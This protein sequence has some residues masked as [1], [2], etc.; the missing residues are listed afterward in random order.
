[1]GAIL[2]GPRPAQV[3]GDGPVTVVVD[4][5]GTNIRIGRLDA[6]RPMPGLLRRSTDLLRR[7]DP[8]AALRRLVLEGAGGRPVGQ[9]VLGLPTSFD[10]R[11]ETVLSSP[12]I[13]SIEGRR[14]GVE[15]SLALGCPVAAERDIVLLGI[16]EWAAGAGGR[17]PTMLGVFMGTGV[18]GCFLVDGEPYRGASGG[19]VEIGHIPLR[20]E[21]RRC[22]CGNL[23]CLEAY[24]CGHVVKALA[25]RAG[26][27]VG[28]VFARPPAAIRTAVDAFIRDFAY[29]LAAAVNLMD[30]HRLVIGGGIPAT[31]SFPRDRL[32]E[33]L[34]AHLRRPVPAETLEIAFARLGSE[35]ALWGAAAIVG[36]DGPG[37][38]GLPTL[39]RTA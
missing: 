17:T 33:I 31:P 6:G 27:P 11:F 4:V 5:G 3:E 28:E 16:G 22:V 19:V 2:D 7:E 30:P 1:M 26:I 25:A 23:D 21:G 20:A 32:V 29:A 13:P 14:L 15:L 8:V 37:G 12:N 10:A 39:R 18:G 9:V 38:A 34:R 36:R 35:A 24:A